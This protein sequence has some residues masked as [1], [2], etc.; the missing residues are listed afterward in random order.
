MKKQNNIFAYAKQTFSLILVILFCTACSDETYQDENQVEEG[1][2]V[3]VDFQF[4]TSEMQK[5]NTR[6]S[7]AGEF[8]VNDLYLFIF[9]SQGKKKQGSHYYNSDALTGFGHTNGDQSSPTKGTI[10]GIQT[11]SG[12]SYIYGI[13]NVEGNELYRNGELKAK[14]DRVN[15]VNELKAIFTTLNNDGNINRETPRL[16]MSGTFESADNTITNEAKAEGTCYIPVRGGAINGTLRLCRL[17]SHI[18]F[19]I[20]LGDK[21]EKF[22]LTSWQVYNIPTSS[23]LIAHTDNYPETTYSNSG[24]QNS[25]ITIDNNVYSF[26]FYMQENLKEAITQDREGNVLSKYTDREKE[27]KNENGGNTGEY[28]HVEENATYVEIKAKMN[29]TN[30]SNPDGIRTADVKYII[31]LGGGANDIENFKSK[32]NKKYTYNVTIN[33]VESIIVEVQGG[34]D[35][36]GANPGVEGDV[37]D[38]KTIVYSLDAHYN[39]I[40]LGF[41]YEEIKELSF[42]IQSPFADDAIYSETGKLPGTEKDAGDYKWIKLQ[43]TTDAQTLAKYREKGTTPIYLYDLKKDMESRGADLGYNQKKTYYYTIFIDEYYY[44]TPPTDKAAKKWTDKSHYW[45]YFV[46]KENRKLLLFLSP[47][48]SADKESSYSEAKYM[49]TQRSIQTYYSTTDLNDDG[50]A[51]GM[52]HVNETGAPSWKLTSSN[53]PYGD[54]ASN[55]FGHDTYGS[56]S[57]D[58]GFYNT[59]SYIK[60]STWDSYITYTADAKGYT[61]TMK[62]IAA[63]AECLS[64]NRDENGN[65]TIDMD[66][67]KWYLP[68]SAQLMSMFLGAKSL[69]SP[70]F[71]DSSITSGVTGDDTRYHYITSDG[72]KI[73]SEEGCSF[74]GFLGGTEGN[75][76]FYSPQQLRCVRNLGLT[77]ANA[78][79]KAKTVSPAYTKS[80]NNF[81]MSYMTPQNIRP[82]KVEAELERHDNFS[83]T[84]RPYKAFQMANSFVDQREGSGVVWKSIFDIDTYHNSKCKNYTEG[85]YKWRAPN[86]R[87]LMIMFLTD[88]TNVIHSYD[89]DYYSGGYKY[90][91]RSFSRTHWRFGD[92]DINKKRHFGIDGE[93][94][95]LDSYNSSYKMTIRCVRDID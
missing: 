16:L 18:Q 10:T 62:D 47:Q 43:R 48:Y 13:A 31:H 64:R 1:I 45:K 65:G 27:Y 94:L 6:L 21:I 41:T 8:Q 4:N 76:K 32:R 77:N 7:D 81:R 33:D 70:L 22:E 63:I 50:N 29:I 30:A 23:Y 24:E 5:I 78:D 49:F 55:T 57:V 40:N 2:P 51:L 93:V 56:W 67:V 42:I 52:E 92:T 39:C 26:G 75:T 25:G 58:N 12:K 69:P 61:Y 83:D 9:N 38:A 95:F 89:Y 71:D 84:N 68:A 73:W 19:K 88:K 90:T 59:Y 87:E 72:L 91:D 54:Q 74:S 36:E 11:T 85:G 15:S 35:E 17:D 46:N 14:L 44:D 80:N 3:E 20:N 37:V 86:Q 28:R 60:N 34:E 79:Q 53:R 82:G 66:E